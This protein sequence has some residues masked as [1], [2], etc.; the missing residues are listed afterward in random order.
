MKH[1]I[2]Y[3]V[4]ALVILVPT[5]ARSA[6]P[7]EEA[8]ETVTLQPSES[9]EVVVETNEKIKI[10]WNHA[11]EEAWRNCKNFC[12]EMRNPAND[13]SFAQDLGGAFGVQPTGG[14]ATAIFKN[15]ESF[16]LTIEIFKK[17]LN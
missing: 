9:K 13:F 17:P 11:D 12:I 2:V 3:P 15:L 7:G 5:L 4:L 10:G 8:I 16:P 1:A 6:A 14:K